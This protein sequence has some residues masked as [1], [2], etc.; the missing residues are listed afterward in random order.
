M[1]RAAL[2]L[3]RDS[4]VVLDLDTGEEK[5]RAEVPSPG[6]A[7]LFPAPGFDR[8]LYYLSMTTIAR[9]EVAPSGA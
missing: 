2:P 1:R 3:G 4:V 9:L 6:Q 8:D 7:F 5:A